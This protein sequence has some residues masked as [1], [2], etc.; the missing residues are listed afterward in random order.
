MSSSATVQVRRRFTQSAERVFDAFLDPAK[1]GKFMF[2]TPEG[3]MMRV[4]IDPRVGGSYVFVERRDGKDVEHRCTFVEIARPHRI[5]FD[6]IVLPDAK[7]STRVS[8]E[9]EPLDSG[10][11]VVLT[12]TGVLPEYKSRTESG[13]SAI[14]ER[15]SG[16]L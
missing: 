5:V 10:C 7:V 2:A 3:R 9:I 13:W 4:E 6:F 8:I 1:A 11:E 12:H 14:L 15:L 16:V